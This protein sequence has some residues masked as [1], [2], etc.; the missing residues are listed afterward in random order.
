L[1]EFIKNQAIYVLQLRKLFTFAKIWR[2]VKL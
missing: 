2:E 1:I